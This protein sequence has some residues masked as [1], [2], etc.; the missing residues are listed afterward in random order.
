MDA[1]LFRKKRRYLWFSNIAGKY[2]STNQSIIWR[3]KEYLTIYFRIML[4]IQLITELRE[5]F[6]MLLM[7]ITEVFTEIT[8]FFLRVNSVSEMLLRKQ[9]VCTCK[10]SISYFR[11]LIFSTNWTPSNIGSL[12][13]DQIDLADEFQNCYKIY[14]QALQTEWF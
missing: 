13:S 2:K 10:S 14:Y 1:L 11:T 6:G 12:N 7:F 3:P 8:M 5:I 4:L 9:S